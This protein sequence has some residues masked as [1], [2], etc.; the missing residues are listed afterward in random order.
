MSAYTKKENPRVYFDIEIEGETL[1]ENRIEM[2][3]F[4]NICPLTAENFRV[5]C[6]GE[7][8]KLRC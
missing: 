8:R 2:E 1:T 7:K 6:T 4:A 3:L 5:L